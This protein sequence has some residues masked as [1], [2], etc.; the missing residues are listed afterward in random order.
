MRRFF[1]WLVFVLLPFAALAQA[2]P[3]TNTPFQVKNINQTG[4]TTQV[5]SNH[6]WAS[7]GANIQ[8]YADRVLMGAAILNNGNHTG[9]GSCPNGDWWT[10][11]TYSIGQGCEGNLGMVTILANPNS[12]LA[13]YPMEAP[14][15]ALQ[16]ALQNVNQVFFGTPRVFETYGYNNPTNHSGGSDASS[17]FWNWYSETWYVYGSQYNTYGMEMEVVAAGPVNTSWTPYSQTGPALFA[18]AFGAGGGYGSPPVTHHHP[19]AVGYITA[20]PDQFAAGIIF[21]DGSIAQDANGATQTAAIMMPR[22]YRIQWYESGTILGATVSMDTS[23]SLFLATYTGGDIK[24]ST[25]GN[26][27]VNGTSGA[28]CPSGVT[29]GTVVVVKGLVTHC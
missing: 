29:A 2:I 17:P 4:A 3:G 27:S 21:L 10:Q 23:N 1:S 7:S 24:L 5:L 26:V 28:S 20:N 22:D 11:T 14:Q 6:F 12:E 19:T 16:V 25:S 9:P 15:A 8:R 13:T 18:F